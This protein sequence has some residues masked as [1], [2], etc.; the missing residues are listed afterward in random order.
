MLLCAVTLQAHAAFPAKPITIVVPFSAGGGTDLTAR[1]LAKSMEKYAGQPVVVVNKVGAGGEIG[2]A[3]V[4][5]APADGY[6]LSIVN[7]PN[8]LTIPIERSAKFGLA[9]FDLLANVMDDPA[10]LSVNPS[11]GIQSIQDLVAAAKKAPDTLTYGTAGIGSA[12]HV[13]MLM[14]EKAAGIKLRHVPFKGTSEVANALLGGHIDV[15]TANLG[16]ALGFAKGS[17]WLILGQM[18]PRRSP[19]ARELPTF[20]E[21]GYALESGS[22]RG[23]GAPRG[24]PVE[25]SRALL[26]II[27]KAVADPE[28]RE[29]ALKAQQD[30][31]YLRQGE[32]QALMT[33]MKK[34]YESLWTTSPWNQ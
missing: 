21:A 27:D 19:M 11:R 28:F 22:L 25:T 14:L 24:L 34:R 9:S 33:E 8:A 10:T 7:T 6:M 30:V 12:G 26:A 15:A 23:L 29:A 32:Y 20:A 2:M 1:L 13:S 4:A 31:R 18:A 17:Q 3:Q 16:E 5:S